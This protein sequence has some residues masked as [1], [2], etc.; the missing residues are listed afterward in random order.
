M[1]TIFAVVNEAGDVYIRTVSP[2]ETESI[3]KFLAEYGKFREGMGDFA[4][5]ELFSVYAGHSVKR[6]NLIPA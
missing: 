1:H 5:R 3:A 6:F 4:M 2:F